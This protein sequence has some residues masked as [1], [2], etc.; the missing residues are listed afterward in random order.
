MSFK[1]TQLADVKVSSATAALQEAYRN[2][3]PGAVIADVP[4]RPERLVERTLSGQLWLEVPVQA[5][6]VPL[7]VLATVKQLS[8]RIRDVTGRIYE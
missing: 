2:F 7:E 8:I 6:P 1:N 3:R 5:K 4:S